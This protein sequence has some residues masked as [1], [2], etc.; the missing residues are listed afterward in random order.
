M[1]PPVPPV[2]GGGGPPGG[3]PPQAGFPGGPQ[4]SHQGMPGDVG[5]MLARLKQMQQ[6][7]HMQQ[8]QRMAQQGV[9]PHVIQMLTARFSGGGG[10]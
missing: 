10:A 4:F 2:G 7:K 8:I 3:M 1:P 6:Q 5:G 9:P